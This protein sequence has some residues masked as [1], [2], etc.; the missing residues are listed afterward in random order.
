MRYTRRLLLLLIGVSLFG[1][2]ACRQPSPP[3]PTEVVLSSAATLPLDPTDAAWRDAPEYSAVLVLQDLVEPR[4]LKATTTAVRARAITDGSEVVFRLEW[5][6]PTPDDLPGAAR[7]SDACAVQ[8][9]QRSEVNLL[10]PQMG[11]PGRPV[12]IAYWNAAWQARVDGRGDSI[13]DL[14]PN[15]SIDHYPFEADSLQNDPSAQQAMALRYAP[16]RAVGNPVAGPPPTPVQDLIAEGPGTLTPAP[17]SRSH[18]QGVRT[19]NGWA[20]VI[21][22][23]MPAAAAAAPLQIAFAV[24]DGSQE[25]VG[26]RKMR[27]GW[28]PMT[29]QGR[30]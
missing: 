12:E 22:R 26:A 9:P 17:S 13:K 2:T 4:Q 1:T 10:A 3:P 15:A 21:A 24:W 14:Y 20:V 16:A 19:A 5:D 7:F 11:E 30:P 28:I 23:S 8:V 25:E 6:D 29:R 27:T 18:G